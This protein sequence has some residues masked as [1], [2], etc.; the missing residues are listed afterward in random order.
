MPSA[1]RTASW[2]SPTEQVGPRRVPEDMRGHQHEQQTNRAGRTWSRVRL[3]LT[4]VV[5]SAGTI[6]VLLLLYAVLAPLYL[7]TL[8]HLFAVDERLRTG[9]G[10]ALV[11]GVLACLFAAPPPGGGRLTARGGAPLR[12][13][14]PRPGAGRG[15]RAAPGAAARH[16]PAAGGGLAVGAA[17]SGRCL[18]GHGGVRD[19]RW[20]A[21]PHA[22]HRA[23][24]PDR[25]R[26]PR[27][28]RAAA[29]GRLP[30]LGAAGVLLRLPALDDLAGARRPAPPGVGVPG[31]CRGGG[32]DGGRDHRLTALVR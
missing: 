8:A 14:G 10:G 17:G 7:G 16:A 30:D 23:G 12:P 15:P 26:V 19:G 5:A 18:H 25:G 4:V 1:G 11:H 22:A 31:R 9:T 24:R 6:G 20:A 13:R 27:R 32:R 29:A 3:V 21:G 28:C 2:R